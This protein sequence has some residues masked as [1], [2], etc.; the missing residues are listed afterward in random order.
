M[1]LTV[2]YKALKDWEPWK[3]EFRK[4]A[5]AL[6]VWHY[7]DLNEDLDWPERL[8]KPIFQDYPKR[9]TA[10]TTRNTPSTNSASTT[11]IST[12]IYQ[13]DDIDPIGRPVLLIEMT[14]D[15][16]IAYKQDWDEFIYAD[17][18]Y[19]DYMKSIRELTNWVLG[20]VSLSI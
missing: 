3:T 9:L 14:S 17:R 18:E 16:R 11:T 2:T 6:R 1:I 5:E 15:G 19:K 20:L 10:R 8:I 12:G 13:L 4:R 7:I